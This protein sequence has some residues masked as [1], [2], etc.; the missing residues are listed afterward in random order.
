MTTT[1]ADDLRT[2]NY[3]KTME[4]NASI[5]ATFAAVLEE[6]GP[7]S[8]M[9]DGSSLNLKLEA[10]PGGRWYRDLGAGRGHLWA[11]VQV[12][13]PPT[14]LELCGPMFMSY[15]AVSHVQY[16]LTPSARGTTLALAHRAIGLITTEHLEGAAHGWEYGL[17]RVREI[18][19][20]R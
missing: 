17:T 11:H 4:V 6:L 19:E 9:P 15:P 2:M 10:W 13:K 20:G 18:A 1:A 12:I 7:G 3:Q 8:V 5:E 14:L 16:R